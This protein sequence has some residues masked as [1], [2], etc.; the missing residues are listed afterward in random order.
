MT[1]QEK[2]ETELTEARARNEALLAKLA[3]T[4]TEREVEQV[5]DSWQTFSYVG[6]LGG[7]HLFSHDGDGW[8]GDHCCALVE[9]RNLA[10]HVRWEQELEKVR[11]DE[12]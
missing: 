1:E 4:L 6:E 9:A 8:Y 3:E 10:G 11:Y 2:F 7:R 12:D 5:K